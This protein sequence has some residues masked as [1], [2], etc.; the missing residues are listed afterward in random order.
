MDILTLLI[1]YLLMKILQ[2]D[3]VLFVILVEFIILMVVLNLEM[4]LVLL[5]VNSKINHKLLFLRIDLL[6]QLYTLSIL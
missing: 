4:G 1:F 3:G 2:M 6:I 5:V